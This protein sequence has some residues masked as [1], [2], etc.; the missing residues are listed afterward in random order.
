MIAIGS[1]H[2][3]TLTVKDLDIS[4]RFYTQLLGLQP[5]ERPS[6]PFKGAWFKVGTQQ[7]HLIEREE[8]QR[9]SSQVIN[10]QQ[11]HVAFRVKNI[12]KALQ[13]LRTNGYK[14]DHPDPTQ[15]LLVNLE[16]RAGFPQIFLF[17]PDG[18]LLEINAED[19]GD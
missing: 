14:E 1:I 10:P 3:V 19:K 9:T 4:I 5:I 13:W 18:H 2:H 6:F 8:K 17:D 7:L 16:S 11:Q 12:Q 15:R